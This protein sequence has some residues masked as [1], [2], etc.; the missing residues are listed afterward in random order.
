[1]E[2]EWASAWAVHLDTCLA[3]LKVAHSA[4]LMEGLTVDQMV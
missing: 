1:M 4:E 3:V 2:I